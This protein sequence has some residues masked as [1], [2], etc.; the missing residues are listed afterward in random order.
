MLSFPKRGAI[1]CDDLQK[2]I[3]NL[4]ADEEV[5]THQGRSLLEVE[6]FDNPRIDESD[7]EDDG[8]LDGSLLS[9]CKFKSPNTKQY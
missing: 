5:L 8:K 6:K 7:D 2:E 3:F 9:I 4:G 1:N